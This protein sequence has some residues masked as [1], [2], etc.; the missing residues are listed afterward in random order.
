MENNVSEQGNVNTTKA[1]GIATIEFFHPKSNSLPAALLKG[2]ADAITDLGNGHDVRVIVLKSTGDKAFC[3]GASFE[4]L[5]SIKNEKAGKKFFMG[6]AHVINAMRKCPFF[7]IA[8]VQGKAVGGGVGLAAAADI[9]LALESSSVKL[10][11]L[12]IGIGPFVIG[13]AVQRKIGLSAFSQL[14]INAAAWH[15]AHW[16]KEK[17][18]YMQIYPDVLQLDKALSDISERLAASSTEAIGLLKKTLWEGTEHWDKLLEK[19]AAMSGRLVLSDFTAKAIE[20]FKSE[21]R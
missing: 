19:R 17:G 12:S 7:V 18:L 6:F 4:E 13:P 8:R 3:A 1:N 14:S 5:I 21:T 15:D 11:E 20:K 16:A 10:S 2:I 9:C